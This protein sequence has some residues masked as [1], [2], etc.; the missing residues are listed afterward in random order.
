MAANLVD[1]LLQ[2]SHPSSPCHFRNI[3]N[4]RNSYF[5]INSSSPF[6]FE[7]TVDKLQLK[8]DMHRMKIKRQIVNL[9]DH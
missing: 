5:W 7:N 3:D 8:L 2:A 1:W 9:T 4:Q 6:F